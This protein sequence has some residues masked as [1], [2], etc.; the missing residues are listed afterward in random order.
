MRSKLSDD[1]PELPEEPNTPLS[2]VV[3]ASEL[4]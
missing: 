1:I 2:V 4:N 3:P